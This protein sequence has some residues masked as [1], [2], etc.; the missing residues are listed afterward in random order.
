MML[1]YASM[2][3]GNAAVTKGLSTTNLWSGWNARHVYTRFV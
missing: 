3:G 1:I 2:E